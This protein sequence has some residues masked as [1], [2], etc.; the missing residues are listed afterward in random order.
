M[1]SGLVSGE[2]SLPGLQNAFPLHPHEGRVI[3][4][5]SSSSRRTP[6]V[7]DEDAILMTSLSL[8]HPLMGPISK[9][10]ILGVRA[11]TYEFWAHTI[12]VHNGE[13]KLTSV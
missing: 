9:Y 3:S 4:G 12:Q 1:L 10:I 5:V 7:L 6:V 2:P 11:S 8:Y 13:R